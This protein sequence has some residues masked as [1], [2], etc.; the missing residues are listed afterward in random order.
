MTDK[1][2]RVR[3][4]DGSCPPLPPLYPLTLKQAALHI[5]CGT[6]P[7]YIP[8]K[9]IAQLL[10]KTYSISVSSKAIDDM[11]GRL[12]GEGVVTRFY[13]KDKKQALF[14][15]AKPA[16]EAVTRTTQQSQA[17]IRGDHYTP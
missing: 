10:K 9:R 15:I 7:N 12:C 2:T 5:L 8:A 3:S 16:Q 1:Q 4:G 11:M 14:A 17:A 13:V 6:W